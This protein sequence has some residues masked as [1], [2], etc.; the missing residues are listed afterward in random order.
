[1]YRSIYFHYCIRNSFNLSPYSQIFNLGFFW[2]PVIPVNK[3]L[4]RGTLG[5]VRRMENQIRKVCFIRVRKFSNKTKWSKMDVG[6]MSHQSSEYPLILETSLKYYPAS[7]HHSH[8]S[9]ATISPFWYSAK[10]III[11][12]VSVSSTGSWNH[13]NVTLS[14]TSD[15]VWNEA[16]TSVCWNEATVPWWTPVEFCSILELLCKPEIIPKCSFI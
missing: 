2:L 4:L 6:K 14:C 9:H 10:G 5:G 3:A 13:S 12:H 11:V 15:G 16:G 1:M 8:P 7:S